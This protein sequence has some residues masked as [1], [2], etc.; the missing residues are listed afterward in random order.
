MVE[1][2]RSYTAQPDRALCL[3]PLLDD[4]SLH[5]KRLCFVLIFYIDEKDETNTVL[6]FRI[7]E[8]FIER[9]RKM[10]RFKNSFAVILGLISIGIVIGV[11][12]TANFNIDSKTIAADSGKIYSDSA[13]ESGAQQNITATNYNPNK[14]FVDIVKKVR[15]TIVSIYTTKNVKVPQN[16]FFYFFKDFRNLPNDQFHQPQQE[17]KQKGLGSGIII[18]KDGYILTNYHVVG[19]VDEL[20][21][22]LIDGAEYKAKLIGADASTEVALIKID[23]K[24][25]PVAILGNSENLQIGEWVIAIGNP[26]ELTSTVTAGIVSAL[27]RDINIIRSHGN[28]NSIENFIQT[29]AAINPGNS[30]GALVNLK[31]QVIGINTAIATSTNYYMG[32]G[33][34][35]PINI[36]KS[37]VDD[38][39]KYG[40]VRRGYLGVYIA[41]V[42]PVTAKGVK[43]K[44]PQGVF[45]T[46][47]LDGG[48]AQEAGIKEGDVI[49]KVNGKEVNHPNELQAKIGSHNPGDKVTLQIWRNGKTKE[50]TVTLKE[51]KKQAGKLSKS[52]KKGEQKSIADL[53][54]KIKDLNAREQGIYEVDHGVL[55]LAVSDDSPAAHTRISQG[56]VIVELNDKEVESVSDF[57][58]KINSFKKG[59]VVKLKIRSKQG[60]EF[61]DRLVFMEIP[62]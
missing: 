3:S 6:G 9:R 49:L 36:A 42:D 33:F 51:N 52:G 24:N 54:M 16:P 50:I 53:G 41:P 32:Y 23:A 27:H 39:I 15:P 40:E 5:K 38:I 35:V 21:V 10:S 44:K 62:D 4:F 30:G 56:D 31:G 59:A 46:S 7:S 37:V 14:M 58:D 2:D 22:K 26:L 48:A 25:L 61:F 1:G 20:K 43:L 55:V 28:V 47:V 60:N 8:T 29:D 18:S 17:M 13:T 11:V 19:D 12:L 57:K 45:I 34:A